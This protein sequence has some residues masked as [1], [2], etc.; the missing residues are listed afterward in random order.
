MLA[1]VSVAVIRFRNPQL[2]NSSN[3]RIYFPSRFYLHIFSVTMLFVLSLALRAAD[4]GTPY[5]NDSPKYRAEIESADYVRIR[6]GGVPA[7]TH[8]KPKTILEIKGQKAVQEFLAPLKLFS[9]KEYAA[10]CK[11]NGDPTIEIYKNG[12]LITSIAVQHSTALG[13]PDKWPAQMRLSDIKTF[14]KLNE[15][16]A[17]KGFPKY[18]QEMELTR[19]VAN[20][21]LKNQKNQKKGKTQ[22]DNSPIQKLASAMSFGLDEWTLAA[23]KP[24]QLIYRDKDLDQIEFMLQPVSP[25]AVDPRK[26]NESRDAIRASYSEHGEALVEAVPVTIGGTAAQ[27]LVTKQK[28]DNL[29]YTYHARVIIHTSKNMI[30][31]HIKCQHRGTTGTREAIANFVRITKAQEAG[32]PSEDAYVK[33]RDPY[34]SKY[35]K[36]ALY[37]DSD[38]REWDAPMPDHPLSRARRKMQ[39]IVDALKI[40]EE[41]KQTALF[42]EQ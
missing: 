2:M 25:E 40:P 4:I 27:W 5:K 31:L 18:K 29:G 39:A 6:T 7:P 36:D 21:Y 23:S 30:T 19:Q 20:L 24:N 26:L 10:Q 22:K 1:F 37:M 9:P 42:T 33:R 41:V 14:D 35:D 38:D 28:Q 8:E 32:K 16:M 3:I 17:R 13:W 12:K 34:D 15:E 11:C